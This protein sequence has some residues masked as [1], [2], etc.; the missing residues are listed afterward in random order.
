MKERK[1]EEAWIVSTLNN[2]DNVILD[3][4]QIIA[5]K[6]IK[7]KALLVVYAKSEGIDFVITVIYSSKLSKYL[8][9]KTIT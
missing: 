8:K 4:E 7:D 9:D 6:K 1:I 5:A 3:G 2:P